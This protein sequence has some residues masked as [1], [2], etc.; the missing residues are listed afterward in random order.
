[1]R[2]ACVTNWDLLPQPKI[3]NQKPSEGVESVLIGRLDCCY[4]IRSGQ[5]H[6]W[7]LCTM[8]ASY[9]SIQDEIR[10]PLAMF[11][12]CCFYMRNHLGGMKMAV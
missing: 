7:K 8:M 4:Y 6:V 1:M 3:I 2:L 12:R 9:G 10:R 11:E 5:V